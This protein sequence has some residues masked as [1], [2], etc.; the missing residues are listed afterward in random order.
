MN[1][2]TVA[3]VQINLKT[4][5]RFEEQIGMMQHLK[6][7]QSPRGNRSVHNGQRSEAGVG[8][9]PPLTLCRSPVE[10][11]SLTCNIL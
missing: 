9:G 1:K 7:F 5:S 11:S 3:A 4:I 2:H 8:N 6:H 10:H